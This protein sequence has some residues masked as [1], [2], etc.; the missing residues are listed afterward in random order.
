MALFMVAG[1]SNSDDPEPPPVPPPTQTNAAPVFTSSGAAEAPE[2]DTG[3][4]I[5]ATAT[6]ADGDTVTFTISGGED[7]GSFE[8]DTASGVLTFLTAPDFENP[9][10]TNV[11]NVYTVSIDASD[12]NGGTASQTVS[13]TVTDVDDTASGVRFRDTIFSS[14]DVVRDVQFGEGLLGGGATLP[15]FM[16]IFTGTGDTET[17]RP[18]LIAAFGGGFVGGSRQGA[19]SIA[20]DWAQRGYVGATIDYRLIMTLPTMEDDLTIG[21]LRALHDMYAAVRFFREDALTDNEF[22]VRSDAIFVS[23]FSAGAILAALANTQDE[24]EVSLLS[25]DVQNF[26]DD[27]GG[28]FGNSST[29]TSV[30]SAVQGAVS[31]SGA[32]T[33]LDTI[34]IGDPP[35][36]GAHEEFDP[37]VPCR[38]ETT[39]QF[40]TIMPVLS[41]S[42]VITERYDALGLPNE[43]F[44]VEGAFTHVGFSPE[45]FTQIFS[46]SAAFMFEQ[47]IEPLL[48]AES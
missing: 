24:S 22:G 27:N 3:T 39:T 15:L 16:D 36:Y 38:T 44:F 17:N 11:D 23:G 18:V 28:L 10:D 40:P 25:P 41:G 14:V 31:I 8:I 12:G 1:C 30:S 37:V 26:L 43:F 35:F 9:A 6:D 4:N 32:I 34:D 33:N 48:N 2:N 5:T 21:V 42:C 47:V 7:A 13:V 46:D 45:Q 20:R 19:E 29:N